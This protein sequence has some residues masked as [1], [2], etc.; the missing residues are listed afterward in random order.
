M[1]DREEPEADLNTAIGLTQAFNLAQDKSN[2]QSDIIAL[3]ASANEN[4]SE[5][6]QVTLLTARQI[7]EASMIKNYLFKEPEYRRL[8]A[9]RELNDY[10][11]VAIKGTE[12]QINKDNAKYLP[13]GH[14][15][16][17]KNESASEEE[18]KAATI[19]WK[20]GAPEVP[21]EMRAMVASALAT[22]A[23]SAERTYVA[24]KLLGIKNHKKPM[25]TIL[26]LI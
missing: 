2:Y 14:P 3:V 4:V 22:E 13:L 5:A 15:L 24:N 18:L 11:N 20:A 23:G 6:R 9:F 25:E 16:S 26:E 7:L 21:S 12:F 17:P 10:L 19:A 8:V 1:F